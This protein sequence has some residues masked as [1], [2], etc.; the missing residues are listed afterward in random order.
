MVQVSRRPGV[1]GSA[2]IRLLTR[3]TEH[4]V[5]ESKQ[6]FAERLSQWLRWTDAISLSSALNSPPAT[7]RTG[8]RAASAS[9]EERE[10]A[11]VRSALTKAITEGTAFSVDDFAPYRQRYIARQQAMEAGIAPLRG[12]LR[13]V[14]AARSPAMARLAS[15]DA[16]M[17][18]A[19]D[20]H[21]Q[22]LLA[23]VPSLL[24]KYFKRLRQAHQATQ[25]HETDEAAQ[26]VAGDAQAA[27]GPGKQTSSPVQTQ[28]AAWLDAFGKDMQ[29]VLLAE[30]DIRFQPV[31]G[32]LEALRT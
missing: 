15:V 19:L 23:T 25:A 5:P 13:T 30:L 18:Q 2:L 31:E 29:G 32:L 20:P 14:L 11:R 10:C 3:L 24:D 7:A 9:A 28:P 1:T 22:R 26:A 8:A 17:E 27:D 6:A 21:E 4:G 12:R 16:V